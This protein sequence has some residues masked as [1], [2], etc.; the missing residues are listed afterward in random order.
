MQKLCTITKLL[1]A[2]IF[3]AILADG[4]SLPDT[5]D[6]FDSTMSLRDHYNKQIKIIHYGFQKMNFSTLHHKMK[7]SFQSFGI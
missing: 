4:A 2:R 7:S 1:L 5:D 3:R 6:D